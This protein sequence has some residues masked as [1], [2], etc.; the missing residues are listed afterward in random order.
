MAGFPNPTSVRFCFG[1]YIRFLF[2]SVD[3]GLVPDLHLDGQPS[4]KEKAKNSALSP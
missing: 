4:F 3:V 2:T 1:D